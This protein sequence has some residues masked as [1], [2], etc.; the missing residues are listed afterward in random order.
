MCVCVCACVYVGACGYM[1]GSVC[2]KWLRQGAV[3][4]SA[5]QGIRTKCVPPQ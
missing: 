5:Q 3:K 1:C 2:P 4:A